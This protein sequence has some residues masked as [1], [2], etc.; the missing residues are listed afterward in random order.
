MKKIIFT[1]SFFISTALWSQET[2]YYLNQDTVKSPQA[3]FIVTRTL[4][5]PGAVIKIRNINNALDT[6]TIRRN[7]GKPCVNAIVYPLE[8]DFMDV[9]NDIFKQTTYESWFTKDRQFKC[10][11]WLDTNGN[12]LEV[13]YMFKNDSQWATIPPH[14]YALLEKELKSKVKYEISEELKAQNYIWIME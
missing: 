11:L 5:Q 13:E 9:V 14:A 2:N 3:T 7:D 12:I 1:L 4:H 6:V 8:P 10:L